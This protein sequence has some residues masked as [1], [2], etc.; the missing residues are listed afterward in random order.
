MARG[1]VTL[2]LIGSLGISALAVVGLAA[3]SSKQN[4]SAFTTLDASAGGIDGGS[5]PLDSGPSFPGVDSSSLPL[6]GDDGGGGA[7]GCIK[8]SQTETKCDGIDDDCNGR[9]DDLDVGKDGICDCIRIGLIGK[10]GWY[11]SNN[12]EQWL[13][14]H[15]TAVSRIHDPPAAGTLTAADLAPFDMVIL[16]WMQRSYSFT[17][18]QTFQTWLNGHHGVLALSG[19]APDYDVGQPNSLLGVLDLQL[20]G[21]ST[22]PNMMA[23]TDFLPHPV[24]VG[25]TSVTFN[26]GSEVL[27]LPGAI[28]S[29]HTTFARS[30]GRAA[31]VA[32]EDANGARGVV[33]G[34][35]WIEFDSEWS[36]VPDINRF[37]SNIIS[38]LTPRCE[39]PP[40]P[41]K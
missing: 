31:G 9:I 16:D 8:V 5:S 11:G 21:S 20:T 12:F 39:V 19:F 24:T 36:T 1:V 27:D 40:P 7:D 29:T 32:H 2:G 13:V 28:A 25:V 41:P 14:S 6:G 17:E 30:S 15:G 35:E 34:D 37:W 22:F 26:G 18:A 3:C 33:W 23:I 4:V 38:F 10:K